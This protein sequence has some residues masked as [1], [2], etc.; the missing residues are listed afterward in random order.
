MQRTPRQF[1]SIVHSECANDDDQRKPS[2]A[3]DE[4]QRKPSRETDESP[5]NY[6]YYRFITVFSY[7]TIQCVLDHRENRGRNN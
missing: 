2:A 7:W 1:F 4:G 5:H 6:C 3:N